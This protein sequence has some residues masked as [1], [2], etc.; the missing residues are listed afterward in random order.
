LRQHT[1]VTREDQRVQENV[2]RFHTGGKA[3]R[4]THFVGGAPV[5]L[6]DSSV[7]ASP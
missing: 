2:L 7:A 6:M 4:V 3:P 1:R 5:T